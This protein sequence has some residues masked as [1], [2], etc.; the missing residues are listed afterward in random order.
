MP[1][2]FYN[3][4]FPNLKGR[5][6]RTSD[7]AYPNCIAYV[8]GDRRR[9]WWPDEDDY[10]PGSLDFWPTPPSKAVLEA[11]VAALATVGYEPCADGSHEAG[12]EKAAIYA[13]KGI[14]THAALQQQDGAWRSKLGPDEDIEHPLDG[15][16]DGRYGKV[17]ACLKRPRKVSAEPEAPAPEK[18]KPN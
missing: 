12:F 10:P 6:E 1:E 14:V 17:I 8:V 7:P 3:E 18:R 2:E 11:F 5:F 9:R 4:D 15:L 16:E 13:L